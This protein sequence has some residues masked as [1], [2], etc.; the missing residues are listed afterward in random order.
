MATEVGVA[1]V[2]V[3]PSLKSFSRN[4]KSEID[5]AIRSSKDKFEVPLKPKPLPIPKD[6]LPKIPPTPVELDPLTKAFQ[7]D[8]QKDLKRLTK[9]I[10][11]EIPV[12]VGSDDLRD[13][14]AQEIAAIEKALKAEIPTE[15]GALRD[16][17]R[18]LQA[19]VEAA[20]RRVEASI[21]VEIEPE[22]DAAEVVD[23]T[24]DAVRTA[25]RVTGPIK[26]HVAIDKDRLKSAALGLSDLVASAGRLAIGAAAMAHMASAALTLGQV[27]AALAPAAATLLLLPAAA[28]AG[29]VAMG[30]LK[31]AFAGVGD[32]LAAGLEGD[33]EKFAEAL[34]ELA[35]AAQ[36]TVKELVA[37]KPAFDQLKG[38]VQGAVFDG[39]ADRVKL[40]GEQYLPL[41]QSKLTEVGGAFNLA[42]TRT[43]DMVST[44]GFLAD[45]EALLNNLQSSF[46]EL[47]GAVEPVLSAFKDIA[48]VGSEFLPGLTAGASGAAAAFAGFIA[49]ARETGQLHAWISSGLDVLGQLGFLAQDVGGIFSGIFTAMGSAGSGALGPIGTLADTLNKVVNSAGGQAGLT[50]VFAGLSKIGAALE[51]VLGAVAGAL[52]PIATIVGDFLT[53]L[54]PAATRIIASLAL[55]LM[56]LAPSA[57]PLANA[58]GDLLVALTPILPVL[59]EIVAVFADGLTQAMVALLPVVRPL[60]KV[61]VDHMAKNLP[62]LE[63]LI[64]DLV[65][66]L[67][68]LLIALLPIAIPAAKLA[69]ALISF[70]VSE[71]VAPTLHNLADAIR[72][73]ADYINFS[74]GFWNGF[75]DVLSQAPALVSTVVTAVLGFFGAIPG[76]FASLPGKILA[77]LQLLPGLIVGLFNSFFSTVLP[78]VGNGLL[79]LLELFVSL[80]GRIIGGVLTLTALWIGWM[81]D[82]WS[83]VIQMVTEGVESTVRFFSELPGQ[84]MTAIAALPGMIG[85]FF[86]DM[87][88]SAKRIVS[89]GISGIVGIVR[90]LPGQLMGLAG[91][92]ANAGFSLIS[93]FFSGLGQVAGLAY[94]LGNKIIGAIRSGLNAGIGAINSGIDKINGVLPGS[95]VPRIPRFAKGGIV[96]EATLG[97]IGEAG[98]EVIIPLTKPKRAAELARQSGLLNLLAGQMQPASATAGGGSEAVFAGGGSFRLVDGAGRVL[99]L[100]V[101]EGEL[102]LG[103]L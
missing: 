93:G 84:I 75:F 96:D 23:E 35:P 1:Y 78:F 42:F 100:L 102:E 10:N 22:I 76:F 68:E 59:G 27:L 51:P 55:A 18:R 67:S 34:K 60:V 85:R 66:A 25:E 39:L 28:I 62:V 69:S 81:T 95:P 97:I 48:V 9:Q 82:F 101:R 7:A 2:S 6:K 4:L 80:P 36:A 31:L 19:Q 8:L 71:Q 64:T 43:A 14:L 26:L 58:F 74:L 61:L 79:Q 5:K 57:G 53:A 72:L 54:G 65:D 49:N 77:A 56:E 86:S 13:E 17:E 3:L 94:G 20:S 40:L 41:L 33:A 30:T 90:G 70:A 88:S 21:P 12:G 52:V 99:A 16:Y 11:A 89:E 15:P 37:L 24:R 44:P 87:W 91:S 45:V 103:G 83:T 38:S 98:P 46:V 73:V 63:P 32:A 50:A 92:F 47:A 29:A